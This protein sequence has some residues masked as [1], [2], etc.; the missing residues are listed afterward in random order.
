VADPPWDRSLYSRETGGDRHAENH[1]PIQSDAQIAALPVATIAASDCVLGLW[2]TD[3]YRGVDV[4]RAWGFKPKT[5]FVW[6][7]DIVEIDVS[8]EHR[9]L[10]GIGGGR[11]LYETGSAGTGFWNRDRDEIL[12]IGCL[13]KPVCPA[14]GSQGESVWFAARGK[15]SEKPDCALDWFDKHFPNTPKI[16]LNARRARANW[17]RWGLEAPEQEAAE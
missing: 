11:V 7:K 2:C 1:Y 12:L 15:H 17:K 4:L 13:G 16:E 6:I 3:P 14:L 5:Y 10:L 8:I 9:K